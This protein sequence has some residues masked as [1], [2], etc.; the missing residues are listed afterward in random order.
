MRF[1][2]AHA[3]PPFH[4]YKEFQKFYQDFPKES[5]AHPKLGVSALMSG[6]IGTHLSRIKYTQLYGLTV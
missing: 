1:N 2:I 4:V 3:A 6:L 5:F